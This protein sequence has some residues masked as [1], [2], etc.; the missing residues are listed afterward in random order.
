MSSTPFYLSTDGI[1]FVLRDKK[2]E[3][4]EMGAEERDLY[5]CEDYESQIFSAK[6]KDG[7]P[8]RVARKNEVGVKITVKAREE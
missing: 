3:I 8:G 1:L 5:K 2:S 7:G 6:G 4:R